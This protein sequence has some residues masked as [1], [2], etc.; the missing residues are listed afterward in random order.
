M[1]TAIL[2]LAQQLLMHPG[3]SIELAENSNAGI[4]GHYVDIRVLAD[5]INA[6]IQAININPL[7]RNF[8]VEYLDKDPGSFERQSLWLRLYPRRAGK[9]VIPSLQLLDYV[10]EPMEVLIQPAQIRGQAVQV[11]AKLSHKTAWQRQQTVLLVEVASANKFYNL[12]FDK[13]TIDG[14]ELLEIP[15]QKHNENKNG[16]KTYVTRFGWVLIPLSAGEFELSLPGIRY[17]EGGWQQYEFH[18]DLLRLTIKRLPSYVTPDIPVGKIRYRLLDRPDYFIQ[19]RKVRQI[20]LVLEGYGILPEWLPSI[21]DQLQDNDHLHFYPLESRLSLQL[22]PNGLTTEKS[23]FV[24]FKTS[25]FGAFDFPAIKTQYFDS[26][27]GKLKRSSIAAIDLFAYSPFWLYLALAGSGLIGLLMLY[28]TR[29]ALNRLYCCML[30]YIA[31]KRRIKQATSFEALRLALVQYSQA[32]SLHPN[33]GLIQLSSIWR[34]AFGE[35]PGVEQALTQLSQL[36]Y[37][38]A[39]GQ[40]RQQLTQL[41]QQ[42]LKGL[43]R[44]RLFSPRHLIYLR[45]RKQEQR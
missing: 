37:G 24:N 13:F 21:D 44:G 41:S 9:L 26:T 36:C 11:S 40:D 45:Q 18:T 4:Y 22:D 35:H 29:P 30:N 17:L 1:V 27:S 3:L 43:R 28:K 6:P 25:G 5:R 14:F 23:L 19:N 12:E 2:L 32:L 10:S 15:P 42:L 38:K 16:Q 8:H 31:A 39:V 33:P 20:R 7:L 34:Q